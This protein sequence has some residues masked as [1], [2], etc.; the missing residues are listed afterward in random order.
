MSNN[1]VEILLGLLLILLV[2]G[3]PKMLQSF[4]RSTLGKVLFLGATIG[5]GYYSLLA[6]VLVALIYMSLHKDFMLVESM[7]NKDDGDDEHSDLEAKGDFVKKYCKDGKLD[8]S[9][10]PPTL[11]YKDGK[12]NPCDE[13]CEFEVTSSKERMT[14][15]EALRPKESNTIPV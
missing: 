7:E 9:T 8:N 1:L 5:A 11:K 4:T 2:V 13:G 10:N 12:C 6:G 14:V 3:Q 15:D